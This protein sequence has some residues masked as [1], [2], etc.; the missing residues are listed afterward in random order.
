LPDAIVDL[1]A[2]LY[3]FVVTSEE[4][5]IRRRVRVD[6]RRLHLSAQAHHLAARF[7]AARRHLSDD[8]ARKTDEAA[9]HLREMGARLNDR[10]P[11]ARTIKARWD[12]LG[13]SYEALREEIQT[14]EWKIPEGVRLDRVKPQNYLRNLFHV[15]NGVVSVLLCELVFTTTNQAVLTAAAATL[16][17]FALDLARRFSPRFQEFLLSG[18]AGSIAR[19]HEHHQVPSATWMA[20]AIMLGL[21]V[22]PMLAVEIGVLALGI[23]DPAAAIFGKRWGRTKIRGQKSLQG[24]MAFTFTTGLAVAALLTV[25]HPVLDLATIATVSV[26]AG[27]AGAITEVVSEPLDDNF[28][29]PLVVAFVATLLI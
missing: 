20:L 7:Q 13:H 19:A 3:D 16:L 10:R 15:H 27:L 28:S 12:G 24:A 9:V 29:I 4:A 2:S 1:T 11:C 8:V 14:Q 22:M 23:G 5:V 18:P 25:F 21:L 6:A 26:A 17:F